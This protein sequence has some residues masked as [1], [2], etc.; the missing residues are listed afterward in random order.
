MYPGVMAAAA[1]VSALD[2][3]HCQ[4]GVVFVIARH[5][6]PVQIM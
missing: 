6:I 1:L 3:T 4:V 5:V 2:G